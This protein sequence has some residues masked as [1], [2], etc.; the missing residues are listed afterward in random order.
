[1]RLLSIAVLA[2][3][4]LVASAEGTPT[5]VATMTAPNLPALVRSFTA[6]QHD[7]PTKRMLRTDNP[8]A[9][10][11]EKEDRAVENGIVGAIKSLLS[12]IKLNYD[13][14]AML[15]KQQSADDALVFLKLNGGVDDILSSPNLKYLAKYISKYNE[16]FPET[17]VTMAGTLTKQY[18]DDAVAAMLVSGQ[19]SPNTKDIAE[20][21]EG[22]LFRLW[23]A[24]NS[25]SD[26]FRLLK[27]KEADNPPEGRCLS[28]LAELFYRLQQSRSTP[29]PN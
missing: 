4:A 13:L 7:A 19:R 22:E 17:R 26:V 1:M 11:E 23:H 8:Y 2:A 24:G 3:T 16:K 21:L 14:R 18:G 20:K 27:L 12:K 25:Y 28:G 9:V 29:R 15:K 10:D 6:A 5:S